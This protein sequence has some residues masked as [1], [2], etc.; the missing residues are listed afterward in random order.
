MQGAGN[1]EGDK[2]RY[3]AVPKQR[4]EQQPKRRAET[5]IGGSN[6]RAA[7]IRPV[8][9]AFG[10]TIQIHAYA[11]IVAGGQVG[12]AIGNVALPTIRDILRDVDVVTGNH[13]S[14][15]GT[16]RRRHKVKHSAGWNSAR[17]AN[18]RAATDSWPHTL[19][20]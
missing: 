7:A 13:P 5:A 2:D 6:H 3:N 4:E 1:G 14:A 10:R 12:E 19:F 8:P 15:F 18:F 16:G 9:R 11:E 20:D 17:K